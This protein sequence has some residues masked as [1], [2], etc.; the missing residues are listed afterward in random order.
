MKR[1]FVGLSL[2]VVVALVIVIGLKLSNDAIAVIVGVGLG[3]L[4]TVP[5]TIALFFFLARQ[6]RA[7][8]ESLNRQAGLA[9]N[10]QPPV[11]IVSGGNQ[12]A[13]H[14][15]QQAQPPHSM[16]MPGSGNRTFTV[17]GEETTEL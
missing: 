6:N 12:P 9:A 10:P 14:S 3:V 8:T 13:I 5:T 7:A 2:V 17:V 16:Q 15:G 4:A 1:Y 11:V